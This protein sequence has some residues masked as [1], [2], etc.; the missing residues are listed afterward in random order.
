MWVTDMGWIMGPWEVVGAG[1]LGATLVLSR[2]RARPPRPGP[3][4]AAG[5]AAPD[6]GAGCLPHA[7]PGAPRPRRRAG[8]GARPQLAA[9]PGLDRRALEPRPLPLAVRGGGRAVAARS[10]TCRAAPRSAACFLSPMPVMPLKECTLGMPSLGMAMDVLGPDGEPV[11]PGEVGELVCRK[12]L[13]VHDPRHLGRSPAVP[14]RLLVALAGDLGAR[15]L[16]VGRRG[17][18][19]VSARA[20]RRHPQHRRQADR[21]GRVRVGGGALRGRGRGLCDRR[22][23]TR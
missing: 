22:A 3:A 7:D 18:L 20:I 1:A 9:D 6:L 8:A 11:A 21:A 15:R 12:P 23:R 17:R 5:G 19:L 13:A 4:V 14:G 2:G 16:G 10:S